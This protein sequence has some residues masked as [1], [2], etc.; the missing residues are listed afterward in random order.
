[1]DPTSDSMKILRWFGMLPLALL[2]ALATLYLVQVL[3][4]LTM[5]LQ[6]I[7]S[8]SLLTRGFIEFASHAA[9]GAVFVFVAAKVAPS[10]KKLVAYSFAGIGFVTAGFLL[11]P[12]FLVGDPWAIWGGLSLIIGVAAIAYSIASGELQVEP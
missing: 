2:G 4:R 3:N 11:F 10:N 6:G 7:D 1:M 8:G 12:A 5:G 9:M